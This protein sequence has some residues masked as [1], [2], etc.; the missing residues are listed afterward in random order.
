MRPIILQL[1]VCLRARC[2]PRRS[3]KGSA[4]LVLDEHGSPVAGAE[5]AF[6]FPREG[7]NLE[8]LTVDCERTFTGHSRYRTDEHGVATLPTDLALAAVIARAGEVVR[9]TLRLDAAKVQA[10]LSGK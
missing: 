7:R 8:D 10:A 6:R 4:P 3:K 9:G 5:V 1:L 2:S